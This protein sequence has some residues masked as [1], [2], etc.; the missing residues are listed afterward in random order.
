VLNA[1]VAACLTDGLAGNRF[2][3]ATSFLGLV[4]ACCCSRPR[5]IPA[6]DAGRHAA[7]PG[8]R[9]P[10]F[11]SSQRSASIAAMQPEPAAVT[12]WRYVGSWASPHANTPG[13]DVYVLFSLV[14]M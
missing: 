7:W 10:C 9:Y 5:V 1:L 11:A 6:G 3:F 13:T 12:A 4:G 2:R 14:R 8:G